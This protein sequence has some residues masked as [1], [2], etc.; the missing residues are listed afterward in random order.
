MAVELRL[1]F[2]A[3]EAGCPTAYT[4]APWPL[5][6][7]SKAKGDVGH[8]WRP[9]QAFDDETSTFTCRTAESQEDDT[10]PNRAGYNIT[11][12]PTDPDFVELGGGADQACIPAVF[13]SQETVFDDMCLNPGMPLAVTAG[14]QRRSLVGQQQHVLYPLFWPD[15]ESLSCT[16]TLLRIQLETLCF[17]SVRSGK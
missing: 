1:S 4:F 3:H 16:N 5:V 10:I 17:V 2:R 6:S 11:L 9:A 12:C 13:Q 14:L 7:N 8:P 15:S